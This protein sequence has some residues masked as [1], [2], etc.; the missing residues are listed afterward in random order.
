MTGISVNRISELVARHRT[1][2]FN[3]LLFPFQL[4]LFY[5]SCWIK[6]REDVWAFGSYNNSFSDNSKY[7]FLYIC[8]NC[9]MI[10]AVW[11]TNNRQLI[12][13]LKQRGFRAY[14][15]YGLRGLYYAGI[16]RYHIYSKY[17]AEVNTWLSGGAERINLWHG[18]NLKKVC[19]DIS[20]GP[21]A[22]VYRPGNPIVKVI[23]RIL[24]PF[25]WIMDSFVLS[26]SDM[27]NEIY[28][29]AYRIKRENV[30]HYLHPRVEPFL[31]SE[32]E[33]LNY[34][35]QLGEQDNCAWIKKLNA[36]YER[37]FIYMPTWRDVGSDFLGTALPD[38]DRLNQALKRH[39]NILLIKAHPNIVFD[40]STNKSHILNVDSQMDIY[41]L[42]PYT[43]GL[44]SDYSSVF[45]DYA[46]L[47]KRMACYCFDLDTYQRESRDLYW[48]VR[49]LVP[50]VVS[51][52][53]ELLSLFEGDNWQFNAFKNQS[54]ID[55]Y[56]GKALGRRTVDLVNFLQRNG[57]QRC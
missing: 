44:I 7:L 19:W 51:H 45:I 13:I 25:T 36:D 55:Q 1:A 5:A 50:T 31:Y 39:N 28:T 27:L 15:R 23:M 57:Q 8:A 30:L 17:H 4:S 54:I 41:T 49:D 38:L 18:I 10:K 29:Q 35:D 53:D 48:D 34:F 47:N 12:T 33:R 9:P 56:W 52:F 26:G 3:L 37:V 40:T 14:H 16:A 46:L 22:R 11:I 20:S 2:L 21:I 24:F 32:S 6:R 43:D 42:L